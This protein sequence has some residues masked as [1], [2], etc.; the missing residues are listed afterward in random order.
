M[1]KKLILFATMIQLAGSGYC[2]DDPPKIF[3]Q[4]I[5][6]LNPMP[7]F[8]GWFQPGIEYISKKKHAGYQLSV[9]NFG[10]PRNQ[11]YTDARSSMSFKT[12]RNVFVVVPEFRKYFFLRNDFPGGLYGSISLRYQVDT[13]VHRDLDA[14]S[15]TYNYDA[16]FKETRTTSAVGFSLGYQFFAYRRFTVDLFGGFQLGDF[17]LD[18]ETENNR[19]TLGQVQNKFPDFRRQFITRETSSASGPRF[20]LSIGIGI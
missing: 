10:S 9:G 18:T 13:R 3:T 5:I 4:S 15:A 20:G 6:K 16:S 14:G 1:K 8:N 7:L 2:G 17:E 11:T 19:I 12:E